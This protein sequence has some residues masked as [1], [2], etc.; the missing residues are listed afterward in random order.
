MD[1]LVKTTRKKEVEEEFSFKKF[2]VP[3]YDLKGY[4]LDC[5]YWFYSLF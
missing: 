5:D 1:G 3:F 4:S 2:F